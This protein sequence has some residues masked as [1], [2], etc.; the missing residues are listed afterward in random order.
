VSEEEARYY[1]ELADWQYDVAINE[2]KEDLEFERQA[3][4]IRSGQRVL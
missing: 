1:L 3:T 2:R 4:T